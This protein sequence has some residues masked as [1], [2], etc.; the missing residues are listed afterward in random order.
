MEWESMGSH[1]LQPLSRRELEVLELISEGFSNKHIANK[2][3]LSVE[4]VKSH[5]SALLKKLGAN[6][7][8]HAVAI[9]LRDGLL[10]KEGR[11]GRADHAGVRRGAERVTG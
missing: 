5:V 4:T 11:A 1:V 7:R 2:L 9:A 8:A 3:W 10:A 6:S